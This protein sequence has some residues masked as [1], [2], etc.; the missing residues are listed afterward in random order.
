MASATPAIG[1]RRTTRTTARPQR[2][3]AMS[4]PR[5]ARAHTPPPARSLPAPARFRP[6]GADQGARRL[7][8]RRRQGQGLRGWHCDLVDHLWRRLRRRLRDQLRQR[9][10]LPCPAVARDDADRSRRRNFYNGEF[11]TT[12][13]TD[14]LDIDRSFDTGVMA[15]PLNVAF[16]VEYRQRDLRDHRRRA[17]VLLR[18][19]RAVV[20]R[21]YAARPGHRVRAPTRASTSTWRPTRSSTCT[22]TWRAATSTTATSAARG[23]QGDRP[24]RLHSAVRHPR[25][26]QQR[27]PR[28]DAGR[29]VLLRH[30]RQPDLG[31]RAAAA[32][33]GGRRSWPASSR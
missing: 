7:V 16:G 19:R 8:H 26:G 24:V 6:A 1:W 23:R 33:L 18:R 30:Q 10:T 32:E 31:R 17:V 25:H 20:R 28:A 12:Q 3:R 4:A 14:N 27:L 11:N 29:G 2:C 13:W 5:R 21:L 9:P 22:S 15:S